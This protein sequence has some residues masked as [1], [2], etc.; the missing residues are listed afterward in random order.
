VRH[1]DAVNDYAHW[2]VAHNETA[3]W[4]TAHK[5]ILHVDVQPCANGNMAT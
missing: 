4:P 3:H 1:C 5:K 2:N